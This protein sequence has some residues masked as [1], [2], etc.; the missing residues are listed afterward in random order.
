[1]N[2]DF[3]PETMLTGHTSE[4]TAYVVDDYPYGFR[5]RTTIRYWIETTKRGD[6]FCSQTQNPKITDRVV[7]NKPKK[8]TYSEVMFLYLEPENGHVSHVAL[9]HYA[10]QEWFDHFMA[11]A[12]EKL[13]EAQ[14]AQVAGIIGMKK[15]MEGV[16][17]EIRE[18]QQTDEEKLEQRKIAAVILNRADRATAEALEQL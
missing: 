12:G 7:W 13:S 17:W 15:A 4:D 16:T 18:G 1:M 11:V 8:S 6:R 2:T 9:S 5:L 14:K 3:T 10:D